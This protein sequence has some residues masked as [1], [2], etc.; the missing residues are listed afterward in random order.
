MRDR[1]AHAAIK[2]Y[3]YQFD[4]TAARILGLPTPQATATV[5]GIEDIDLDSNDESIFVQC[6][7]YERT[8]YNHSVIKDAVIS[9]LRHFHA[10]GCSATQTTRYSLYGHYRAGQ[11][12]LPADFDLE[13]LKAKFLTYRKD[14]ILHEV[15][16]E[17]GV[18][19]A[20]L[21]YF[22]ELLD[23]DLLAKSYEDQ[24]EAVLKL[25]VDHIPGCTADDARLFYYPAA[26]N[27]IQQLAVKPRMADRKI[28]RAAFVDAVNRKEP[29]FALWLRQKF[30]KDYYAKVIKRRFF[31]FRGLKVPKASRIF[32]IEFDGGHALAETTAL[33]AKIGRRFSHVEHHRTHASDR[34]CPYVLLRGLAPDDLAKTKGNLLK[35]GVWIEDGY[36]Y[37]GAPFSPVYLV[38][39]APTKERLIRLKFIPGPEDL[40][41]L[42]AG[43][44][45]T[46][47]EIFDF[48]RTTPI[49]ALHVPDTVEHH[50]IN[51]DDPYFIAE[52]L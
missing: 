14:G 12:K 38:A 3:F 51:V 39:S 1:S 28:T 7:Y 33:L 35:Q 32:V 8:E 20:Q 4:N 6:K 26:I 50:K 24:Q 46:S 15:Y 40:A 34:F 17:L 5:E 31:K 43:I 9:M 49:D 48:Y 42:I 37:H 11:D 25:L 2:G 52:T 27:V 45:G 21:S 23:I 19:D 13:F 44:T 22:R 18:T 16:S 47:I 10:A 30:G 41:A 29:V 36:G